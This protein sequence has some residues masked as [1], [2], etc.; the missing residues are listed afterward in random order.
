MGFLECGDFCKEALFFAGTLSAVSSVTRC[1]GSLGDTELVSALVF[2]VVKVDA[3]SLYL[4]WVVR[5]G[6]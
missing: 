3:L 4:S 2:A 6:S 1:T 5:L